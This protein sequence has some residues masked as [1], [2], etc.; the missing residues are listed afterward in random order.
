[1][2]YMRCFSVHVCVCLS[3]YAAYNADYANDHKIDHEAQLWNI[4]WNGQIG[5]AAKTEIY[6]LV[7]QPTVN[8][9][10]VFRVLIPANVKRFSDLPY[11]EFFSRINTT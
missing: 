6:F 9:G 1:M 5:W 8:S 11:A 7:D 2:P 4:L 3:G 10:G